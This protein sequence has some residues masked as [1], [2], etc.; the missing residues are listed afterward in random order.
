M[1]C[2]LNVILS[3][4]CGGV[5]DGRDHKSVA[6]KNNT[7]FHHSVLVKRLQPS[8]TSKKSAFCF[9][10]FLSQIILSDSF[11]N[12]A[13]GRYFPK[14]KYVSLTVSRAFFGNQGKFHNK[15]A[16][17]TFGMLCFEIQPS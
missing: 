2:Q 9:R 17:H 13:K 6:V 15:T 16:H 10:K 3:S 11:L 7:H 4:F 1:L 14:K 12:N 5:G 8:H